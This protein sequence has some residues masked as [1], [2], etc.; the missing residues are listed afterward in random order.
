MRILAR[1]G[2]FDELGSGAYIPPPASIKSASADLSEVIS[3]RPSAELERRISPGPFFQCANA[4][5]MIRFANV[6]FGAA[7]C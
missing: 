2:D 3:A 7:A 4:K 1:A 5:S 6:P